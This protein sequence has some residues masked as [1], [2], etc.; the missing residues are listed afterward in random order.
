LY[1][2][3]WA[4]LINPI[5]DDLTKLNDHGSKINVINEEISNHFQQM[6]KLRHNDQEAIR[7]YTE[8]L[9][10]V[11]NDKEKSQD[12]YNR[13]IEIEGNKHSYVDNLMNFDFNNLSNSD[14]YQYI[15][16]ST[17]NVSIFLLRKN[18]MS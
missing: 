18:L 17:E 13:L 1:I 3:F 2:D 8:F 9:N 6:Q 11:L 4:L 14:E 12:Y 16:I 7:L 5:Q 15:F 10:D